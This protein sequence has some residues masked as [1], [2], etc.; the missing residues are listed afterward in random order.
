MNTKKHDLISALKYA[1]PITIPVLIGY[2]FLGMAYGILMKAKGLDTSLAV[3]L[4]LFA[5]CGSM[6]YTAI[7]YLFLAPF[8]P[9]YALVL[10]LMVNSRVAF[11]GISMASKYKS[12]GILKPFLI[13]SLSDETFSIVCSHNIPENINKKAFYFFVSFMNYCYWNIGTLLGCLIGSFITFNTKGLD[14]VLTALFVVIFTEQ[15]LES[16]DHRGA[17]IGLLCSIPILIFKTNIFIILAMILI[18][19]AISIIYK[20][21]ED[22]KIYE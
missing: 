20:Y 12:I 2:I 7:N 21:N 4:S 6:Q 8:N 10:T 22:G 3:F 5:Y 13:F 9:L 18:F 11:Y 1:F 17:L 15:W 14:F 19:L 16:K